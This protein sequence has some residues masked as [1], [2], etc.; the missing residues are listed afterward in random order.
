[1]ALI[2]GILLYIF[3]I[4]KGGP[5]M[6]FGINRDPSDGKV[7]KSRSGGGVVKSLS[8]GAVASAGVVGKSKSGGDI[9]GVDKSRARKG[10]L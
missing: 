2:V 4:R 6:K 9:A 10:T 5:A 7:A 8:G 1:M 3:R